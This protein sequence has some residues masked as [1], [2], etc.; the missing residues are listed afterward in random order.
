[1][2]LLSDYGELVGR[3]VG[4]CDRMSKHRTAPKQRSFDERM[5][6]AEKPVSQ[7]VSQSG[8]VRTLPTK[9][10]IGYHTPGIDGQVNFPKNWAAEPRKLAAQNREKEN[11]EFQ[12]VVQEQRQTQVACQGRACPGK[13]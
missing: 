7:S 11:S 6:A 12:K 13:C 1:M 2:F 4:K 8:H 5:G 9:K 10:G 3:M